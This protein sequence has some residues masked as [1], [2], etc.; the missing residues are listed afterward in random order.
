MYV[1]A[2]PNISWLFSMT[3]WTALFLACISV[4]SR[5]RLVSRMMVGAKTTAR[6]FG[7]IY[8]TLDRFQARITVDIPSFHTLS[9][10]REQDG[11]LRTQDNRD[12][13]VVA[14]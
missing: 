6:F 10:L 3:N 4:I 14:C 2:S 1:H 11:R 12:A 9:S 5:S 8:H 13:L 7:V